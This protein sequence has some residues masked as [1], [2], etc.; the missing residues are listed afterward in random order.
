[1]DNRYRGAQT[2]SEAASTE[3]DFLPFAKFKQAECPARVRDLL[4]GIYQIAWPIIAAALQRGL[5]ELEGDLF[6]HAER[7]PSVN[8]QNLCFES[9]RELRLRRGDFMAACRDGVQRS[10][11]HLRDP[12]VTI[13]ELQTTERNA[14]QRAQ[15]SL[16]DPV[17][18]EEVLVLV[19]VAMRAEMRASDEL[20][21][22]SYRMALIAGAAP[23]EVDAIALGPHELCGTLRVAASCFD[24]ALMHR[25]AM[26]RRI[27]KALFAD[28]AGLYRSINRQLIDA[29]ILAWLHL[30]PRRL[31]VRGAANRTAAPSTAPAGA[32]ATPEPPSDVPQ[33]AAPVATRPAPA[34]DTA[35]PPPPVQAVAA[36]V[37]EVAPTGHFDAN[38]AESPAL[39]AVA[40]AS[41]PPATAAPA[42]ARPEGPAMQAFRHLL[43]TQPVAP[44]SAPAEIAPAPVAEARPAEAEPQAPATTSGSEDQLSFDTLRELLAGRPHVRAADAV[45]AQSD[46]PIASEP[47]VDAALSALQ[48]RSSTPTQ[49]DGRL[50]HRSVADVK[51]EILGQLR[52]HGGGAQPRLRAQDSD[53]IDLVGFLFDHLLADQRPS[54]PAQGLLT[55]LQV[56]LIKMAL[57][58]K[59]FFTQ[60]SHPA[61]Q[62]L[63]AL[64]ETTNF[65][66][67]DDAQDRA[68]VEKMN[69]VVDRVNRDY[70]GDV[71]VFG[72]LFD[73]LSQHLGG[74]KKKAS[75]AERHHVEAARGR[76]K[77]DLARADATKAVQERLDRAQAPAAVRTLLE[78]AWTDALALAL[79][80][81]GADHAQS[82][83]RLEFVDRLI[84]LFG[85]GRPM[86]ECRFEL[87]TLRSEFQEGLASIGYHEVAIGKA[88]ADIAQ[89]VEDNQEATAQAAA[90]AVQQLVEQQPRLG[91]VRKP[92]AV[93]AAA[94]EPPAAAGEP[95]QTVLQ[96]LRKDALPTLGPREAEMADRIKR[97]PF[98]TWFEFTVNQQGDKARRKLC[99]FSPVTGRCLFVNARGAKVHERTIANLA[100]DL[101][102]GNVRI[103]EETHENLIDRAWKSIV[104]MLRGGAAN[105]PARAAAS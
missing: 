41:D 27:D 90:T 23:A 92:A 42:A 76:E 79:L 1:M 62:L 55:R 58:D 60:R 85:H 86:A 51:R 32:V 96:S 72:R 69:W 12:N 47:D 20:Q 88:W 14:G 87:Q 98:G 77:L 105:S 48:M 53:A 10:L 17:H 31:V 22:L 101:V 2:M 83:A 8:D 6:K 68:V 84:D 75:I 63:N 66:V 80:R 103:V 39:A 45:A 61:R 82:R 70:D 91:E 50:V 95:A 67:E 89:L 28:A 81:H 44:Q 94:A 34:A 74:L 97:L 43:H 100:I 25:M 35:P 46:R 52:A 54:S 9:Q 36:P 15:L 71:S 26:Y 93:A 78:H 13:N 73:D 99:W 65:W 21:A 104:A 4:E 29:G 49:I 11:M 40:P 102:R 56:P 37:A 7:A 19:E 33:R 18:F 38:A 16:V 5:D 59:G 3:F 64:V 57:K 24:I 30:T